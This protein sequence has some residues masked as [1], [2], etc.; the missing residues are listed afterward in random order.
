MSWTLV[1]ANAA[2]VKIN[3]M[4]IDNFKHIIDFNR[5]GSDTSAFVRRFLVNELD[6][7]DVGGLNS[8]W[9]FLVKSDVYILNQ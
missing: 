5:I 8:G 1:Q 6:A 7:D 9:N 2:V 4:E 3:T